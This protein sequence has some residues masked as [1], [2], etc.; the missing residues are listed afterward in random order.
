MVEISSLT[1]RLRALVSEGTTLRESLRRMSLRGTNTPG[2]CSFQNS[3]IF[4]IPWRLR[5]VGPKQTEL[6]K[7]II[8]DYICKE[9]VNHLG[10]ELIHQRE[11]EL[12][13]LLIN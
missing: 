4:K 8:I 9:V 10:F 11:D 7:S 1:V 6:I 2:I 12:I 3:R 5:I 13:N